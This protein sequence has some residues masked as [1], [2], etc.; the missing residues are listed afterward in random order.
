MARIRSTGTRPE[1]VAHAALR[2]A[3][4]GSG[5]RLQRHVRGLPGSPDLVV[6]G[7]RLVVFVHGC[8]WHRHAGC[9]LS[10]T[11][12]TR[13]AFWSAKFAANQRRDRRVAR[14]LRARGWRVITLW[15][16]RLARPE[17]IARRVARILAD[18]GARARADARANPRC[19]APGTA[20][21]RAQS[22][23]ASC[24]HSSRAAPQS[25]AGSPARPPCSRRRSSRTHRRADAPPARR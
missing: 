10:S 17:Q 23:G 6:P 8:F 13:R 22:R 9:R 18:V 14:A 1:R 5:L 11:P 12:S 21:A 7:A 25:A 3:L 15:E 16:C 4:R 20:T 2:A 24:S 19:A